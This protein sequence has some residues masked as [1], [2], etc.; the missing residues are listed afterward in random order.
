[1]IAFITGWIA[2][3]AFFRVVIGG[4]YMFYNCVTG[5]W[6][7]EQNIDP[8]P[9]EMINRASSPDPE[10]DAQTYDINQRPEN[11]THERES[12]AHNAST[13]SPP[14]LSELAVTG[15][16]ETRRARQTLCI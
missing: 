11:Q 3:F 5:T 12:S 10:S 4:S 1:M 14:S 6:K 7:S 9:Y 16:T 15:T 8:L 13:K 2:W